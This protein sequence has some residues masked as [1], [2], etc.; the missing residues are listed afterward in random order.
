MIGK[1][2]TE[3]MFYKTWTQSMFFESSPCFSSPVQSSPVQVL[4]HAQLE[5]DPNGTNKTTNEHRRTGLF[6]FWGGGEGECSS[7]SHKRQR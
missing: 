6:F 5:E 1:T 3:S 2:L 7:W 4:Q